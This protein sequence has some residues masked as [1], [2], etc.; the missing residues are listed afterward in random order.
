M[1]FWWALL[2]CSHLNTNKGE[3]AEDASYQLF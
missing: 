1:A 3:K 2:H